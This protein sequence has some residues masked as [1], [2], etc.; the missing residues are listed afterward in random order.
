MR[1]GVVFLLIW[2]VGSA[3]FTTKAGRVGRGAEGG[4]VSAM[5]G[6]YGPPPS[7]P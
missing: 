7:V 2:T 3:L 1:L 5:D 4:G 6:G